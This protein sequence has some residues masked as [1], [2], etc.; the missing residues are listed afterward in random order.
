MAYCNQVST[1]TKEEPLYYT[2][3]CKAI[4]RKIFKLGYA[5][6]GAHL[7][8]CFS[9]VEILTALYLGGVLKLTPENLSSPARN[10][11]VLSKGHAGLALYAVLH[12]CGLIGEIIQSYCQESGC[13]G[14]HPKRNELPGIE[15]TTGSLGHGL[16]Y[17]LG[18]A[19]GARLA[20]LSFQVYCLLGDGECQEGSVWEA[21]LFAGQQRIGN[22]TAIIDSN[23]LQAMDRL[24]A[25]VDMEPFE[26]KWKSFGWDCRRVDGHNVPELVE[27]LTDK[28]PAKPTVLIA[29]TVKGKGVSF[30]EGKALWH[31]RMPDESELDLVCLELGLSK[32]ELV[33]P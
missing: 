9:A 26:S 25:I 4:R 11:F 31:Y 12:E 33:Y 32:K 27:A 24:E 3:C 14:V 23:R 15:A 5:A 16:S 2:E 29:D 17:A 8:G 20:G 18:L 10:R 22:L 19:L 7:G 30:M 21:A 28:N 1:P 6:K 13:L